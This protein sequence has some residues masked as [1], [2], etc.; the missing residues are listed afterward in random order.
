MTLKSGSPCLW[1]SQLQD[2]L[3]FSLFLVHCP[4]LS[5]FRVDDF[6]PSIRIKEERKPLPP[7]LALV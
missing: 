3:T 5:M 4:L 6:S 7:S 1:I 2:R